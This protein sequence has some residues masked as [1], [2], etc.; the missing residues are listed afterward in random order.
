[1][2][3]HGQVD[4]FWKSLFPNNPKSLHCYIAIAFVLASII[5]QSSP[6]SRLNSHTNISAFPAGSFLAFISVK[7][8]VH[9]FQYISQTWTISINIGRIS[10]TL[11][12]RLTWQKEISA[13]SQAWR[14]A[15][16]PCQPPGCSCAWHV[17][18]PLNYRFSTICYQC[19]YLLEP[20]RL[21]TFMTP[22]VKSLFLMYLNIYFLLCKQVFFFSGRNFLL[23]RA[24]L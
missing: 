13:F 6:L 22:R 9:P 21:L 11:I 12:L 7:M 15:Q 5:S 2:F 18:H 20:I 10:M 4:I 14:S 17:S 16:G 23:S 8:P 3:L 19:Y 1:M 24:R